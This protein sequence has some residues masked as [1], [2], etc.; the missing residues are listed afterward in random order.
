MY[1]Y[2]VIRADLNSNESVVLSQHRTET[3]AAKAAS[4]YDGT[5]GRIGLYVARIKA[6]GTYETRLEAGDRSSGY[7]MAE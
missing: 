5:T 6:D 2:A 7:G 1:Q 3:A 4:K